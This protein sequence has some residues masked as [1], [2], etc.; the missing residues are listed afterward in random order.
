MKKSRLVTLGAIILICMLALTGC[1]QPS[2]EEVVTSFFDA[3]TS[4]SYDEAENLVEGSDE[5]KE[6]LFGTLNK[7]E[8]DADDEASDKM[9]ETLFKAVKYDEV[10]EV[11]VKDDVA[12]VSVKVT[13][14]DSAKIMQASMDEVM[15]IAFSDE[16]MNA[17][18]EESTKMINDILL[19]HFTAKDAPMV[20]NTVEVT[21]H[22]TDDGWEIV[23]DDPLLDG[24]TGGLI[25]FTESE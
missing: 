15:N 4:G 8:R 11:S 23:I 13:A 21:L 6:E 22:N 25:S 24:V 10:K 7:E 1:G 19:K 17:T 12:K 9:V 16:Y 3:L 18:D 20:T 14:L 2:P 5:E